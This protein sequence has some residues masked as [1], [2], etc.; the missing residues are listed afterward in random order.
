MSS[1]AEGA[2]A[3]V[4]G[5]T[6]GI[7]HAI[8]A[9]LAEAG[10]HVIINGRDPGRTDAVAAALRDRGLRASASAYDVADGEAVRAAFKQIFRD[11]RRLDV[12]VNNAG[13]MEG[14]LLG[15]VPDATIERAFRV[16][17]IGAIHH[18][19]AA[20]RLMGR[21]RRGAI[22]NI[23]SIQ[24]V[25]G[26][27]GQAVYAASKA[28]LIGLT[29]ASARE[30]APQGIRVNAVSPGIIDTDMIA[31]LGDAARAAAVASVGLGRIGAPADVAAVV[32]MLCS[33]AAGYV[34][35]QVVGV[36]GGYRT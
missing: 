28:A 6:R 32:E 31:F 27:P 19:Q 20:A 26:V 34:T 13:V 29:R 4:T 33:D 25:D 9:R 22:V 3:L 15:L 35:G 5:S 14:G 7:G 21:A 16:N 23:T 12:L 24:A 18:V 11:H 1:W 36:D 17:V 2:V 30:L 10:C 8:A